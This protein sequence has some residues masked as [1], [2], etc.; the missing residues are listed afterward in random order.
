[1]RLKG[2]AADQHHESVLYCILLALEKRK[3]KIQGMV[4]TKC[5]LPLYHC[6]VK[7]LFCWIISR[8]RSKADNIKHFKTFNFLKA[9]VPFKRNNKAYW[10]PITVHLSIP[11]HI[12]S[13]PNWTHYLTL[14]LIPKPAPLPGFPMHWIVLHPHLWLIQWFSKRPSWFLLH[15]NSIVHHQVLLILWYNSY[16]TSLTACW[17]P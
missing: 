9:I 8:N 17:Q 4:S 13:C 15:I 11:S 1:M 6:K 3:C 5:I 12:F 16:N 14:S 7:K 2:A 10:T